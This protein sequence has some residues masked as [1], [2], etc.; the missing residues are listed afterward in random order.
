ATPRPHRCPPRHRLARAL[1]RP[2]GAPPEIDLTWE[3]FPTLRQ[4]RW[5][6]WSR[7]AFAQPANM[8]ARTSAS[9]LPQPHHSPVRP[10]YKVSG[11]QIDNPAPVV[12]H[13]VSPAWIRPPPLESWCRNTPSIM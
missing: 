13:W 11:L 4:K 10:G 6:G 8:V 9:L 2:P 1:P 7:V 3:R 5:R 12:I